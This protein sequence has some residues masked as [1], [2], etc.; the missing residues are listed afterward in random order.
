M[1][2]FGRAMWFRP[3]GRNPRRALGRLWQSGGLVILGL[4]AAGMTAFPARTA[5]VLSPFS[6]ALSFAWNLS[7]GAADSVRS[8]GTAGASAIRSL[9]FRSTEADGLRGEIRALEQKA[10]LREEKERE[11]VRL[12]RLLKLKEDVAGA[13]VAVRVVGGSPAG[14]FS[15]L[16]LD[17]GS[18]EGLRDGMGV[19][20]PAGAVG[21]L[22]SVGPDHSVARSIFDPRSRVSAYVQRSRVAGV[23]CGTGRGCELRYL[24]A[25]D[26]VRVG[27]AVLTSGRGSVF[28][29]GILI[30]VVKR[31]RPE[32][33][34]LCAEVA[35]AVNP[36]RLEEVLVLIRSSTAE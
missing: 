33:M 11:L 7:L 29:K 16:V 22:A 15:T 2:K 36:R 18:G 10:V 23:L 5:M 30:G 35:P 4:L 13:T 17:G 12:Y 27:D 32:G 28:S 14:V 9:R 26:D 21:R 25:G 34:L 6:H 8:A 31:V 19:I 1:K 24:A 3:A 20:A